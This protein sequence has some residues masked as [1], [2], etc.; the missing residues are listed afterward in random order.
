MNT[1]RLLRRPEVE[2][3]YGRRRSAIYNDI[4]NGLFPPPIQFS[5]RCSAW[6]E[7]EVDAVIGARIAGQSNDEVRELVRQLVAAR[8][9][10]WASAHRTASNCAL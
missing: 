8:K 7:N 3:R 2:A 6:P 10:A 9:S 5:S 4:Q 1:T